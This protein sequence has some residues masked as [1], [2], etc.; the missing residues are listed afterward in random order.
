MISNQPEK[1]LK[2][3]TA[4]K[5]N[6]IVDNAREK[7]EEGLIRSPGNDWLAGFGSVLFQVELELG[8]N[9]KSGNI[10]EK[11]SNELRRNIERL[12]TLKNSYRMRGSD[13][14]LDSSEQLFPSMKTR[15]ALLKMLKEH[16]R[17]SNDDF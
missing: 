14:G 3:P 9:I 13:Q 5:L 8:M 1:D 4:S 10:T 11:R 17:D 2:L 15:E 16:L 6:F 12:K 7:I